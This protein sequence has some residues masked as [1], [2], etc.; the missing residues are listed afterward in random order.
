MMAIISDIHGNYPAM[1]AVLSAIDALGIDETISLGDVGGYYCMINECI[2]ELRRRGIRNL[3][4]NHDHYL[5]SSQ[6]CP[7]SNSANT[8]LDWQRRVITPDNLAWL[9]KSHCGVLRIGELSLVHAG[10]NDPLDEYINMI[11]PDYFAEREGTI[12][13]SGHTH[14]Q[15]LWSLGEKWYCNPGSV[16]QPR[17]GDPRAAFAVWTGAEMKLHRVAYDIEQIAAP[18]KAAGFTEHYYSN[19]RSG[20]RIGGKRSQIRIAS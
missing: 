19:L 6:A 8:C 16:G 13:V 9:S 3:L 18:M 2:D 10:W 11:S 15:G 17:D 12:F 20:T 7:R 1:R 14:V 4:G 5:I